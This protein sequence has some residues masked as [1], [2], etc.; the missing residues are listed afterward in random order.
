VAHG[1]GKLAADPA[2]VA[3]LD[4]ALYYTD[5]EGNRN[6]GYPR[7]PNGST[8]DIAGITDATGR[9][10]GLMPHPEDHIRES[11]HPRWTRGEATKESL[12]SSIY[13]NA[14]NWVKNI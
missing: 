10:F 9:V 7:N 3:S 11:Q 14:V 4:I 1:E 12:G 6:P 5:A 8:K 13:L 2:V